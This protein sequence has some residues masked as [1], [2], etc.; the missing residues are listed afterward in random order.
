MLKP[1]GTG[2]FYV[3]RKII[4]YADYTSSWSVDS[5]VYKF[6]TGLWQKLEHIAIWFYRR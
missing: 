2:L 6:L 5:F 4:I 1:I 3:I